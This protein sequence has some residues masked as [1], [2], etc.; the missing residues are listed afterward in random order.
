MS[1]PIASTVQ[2]VYH[3]HTRNVGHL[4]GGYMVDARKGIP[5]IRCVVFPDCPWLE[6]LYSEYVIVRCY[7][8]QQ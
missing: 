6:K 5:F 8:V 1:G 2:N 7:V 4:H 3:G